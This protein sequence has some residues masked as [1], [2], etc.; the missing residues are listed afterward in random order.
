M[1]ELSKENRG[2]LYCDNLMRFL[3]KNSTVV[4]ICPPETDDSHGKGENTAGLGDRPNYSVRTLLHG[5][6]H[7][8]QLKIVGD[9]A[10]QQRAEADCPAE[11]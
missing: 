4:E 5:L 7:N 2:K 3:G 1:G 8:I 9:P 11:Q 10:E 6:G